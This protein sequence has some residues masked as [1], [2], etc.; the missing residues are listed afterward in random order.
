MTTQRFASE[1]PAHETQS[2]TGAKELFMHPESD[3]RVALN[4]ALR[5]L[6]LLE[7]VAVREESAAAPRSE[8]IAQIEA[9]LDTLSDRGGTVQTCKHCGS[10]M[11]NLD[12]TIFFADSEG[13]WNVPLPVCPKC[14]RVEYLRFISSQAA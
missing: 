8:K 14:E 13:S 11:V 4:H 3:E 2:S 7:E 10:E 9:C 6:R 1:F 12:A 5:T